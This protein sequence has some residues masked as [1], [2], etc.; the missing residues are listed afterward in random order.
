MIKPRKLE[1]K[2]KSA[3]LPLDF[4]GIPECVHTLVIDTVCN[5]K[6]H[7]DFKLS[8]PKYEGP[9]KHVN[10][11]IYKGNLKQQVFFH[12]MAKVRPIEKF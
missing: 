8:F 5:D 12:Y 2:N 11:L 10:K 6:K 9:V 3:W 1:I 7:S 4:M